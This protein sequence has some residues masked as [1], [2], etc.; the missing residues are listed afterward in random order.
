KKYPAFAEVLS[1]DNLD[2]N[3]QCAEV[4]SL[5][6]KGRLLCFCPSREMKIDPIERDMEKLG[7]LYWL[8]YKDCS[9]NL[10]RLKEYLFS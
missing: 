2:Y 3:R 4:N 10:D 8:G 9:E 1:R 7:K 5:N 6:R